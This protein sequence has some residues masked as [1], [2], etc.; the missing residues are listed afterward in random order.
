MTLLFVQGLIEEI[1][2]GSQPYPNV[3][4]PKDG[5]YWMEG[6]D[7]RSPP[8]VCH[9]AATN[10]TNMTESKHK[11]VEDE[12]ALAYRRYFIGKVIL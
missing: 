11:I 4:I 2:K 6:T 9:E 10:G 1:L 3:A 8:V 5:G 12:L 7:C